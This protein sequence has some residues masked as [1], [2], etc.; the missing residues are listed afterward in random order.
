MN[1]VETLETEYTIDVRQLKPEP[2]P[3]IWRRAGH[4][5]V[6][7]RA[8]VANAQETYKA[9]CTLM[10]AGLIEWIPNQWCEIPWAAG[11]D[12][13]ESTHVKVADEPGLDLNK[14]ETDAGH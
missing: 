5:R 14:K 9:G 8:V 11:R 1:Y 6:V 4:R 7:P 2:G 12:V 3:V 13:P 10:A